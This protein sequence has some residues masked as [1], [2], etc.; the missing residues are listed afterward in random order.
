MDYEKRY[1]EALERAKEYWETDDDNTLDV[2]VR[3]TME[4]LFPELKESED[5]RIKKELIAIF[6]GQIPYTSKEDAER[7]ITWL[8]KQV[9]QKHTWNEEDEERLQ[10]CLNILQAKGLMGVTETIN[11]KWLKSLKNR[12]QPQLLPQQKCEIE[13][14]EHGK[15]YYCIKDYYSGG[16]KKASKGEVVQA[17]RGMSMMALEAKANEYF[18]P[19]VGIK[20]AWSEEDDYNIEILLCL[21]DN[22]KENYP[23]P[24]SYVQDIEKTYKWLK[25]LRPQNKYDYNPY[26]AVVESIVEMCKHYDKANHSGL[27]DFYDNV[28]VKCKDA[29]EYDTISKI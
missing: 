17:L 8:E 16:C 9:E 12:I 28:K 14:I 2:K 4:Y 6:K 29:I 24:S 25:S 3:R 23:R 22:E 21:L 15:Y 10:S 27:R 7:Y 13:H 11:T 20:S 26:K 5:E 18:I 1:K 19:V